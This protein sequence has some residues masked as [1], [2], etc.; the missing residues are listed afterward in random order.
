VDFA[1]KAMD[2]A[3]GDYS[4]LNRPAFFRSGLQSMLYMYKVFPTTSIQMFMNLSTNGKMGMLAG[5]WMLGGIAAFPFAEDLE[6]LFDTLLQKSGIGE[7]SVRAWA[8]KR[9]DEISPGLAPAVLKG[10]MGSVFMGDIA[11]RVSLSVVPGS[12]ILL[13][14]TN[15][16]RALEE[17]AGP[18]PSALLGTMQFASDLIR[19]P[20]STTQTLE[21]TLRG[22][23]V[24]GLR[25]AADTYAYAQT[26]AIIDRRGY[27]VAPNVATSE[28]VARL[29]GFYPRRAAEQYGNIRV[30]KRVADYRREAT[31]AYRQEWVAARV[32]NDRDRMQEI[33]QA[34]RDW[35]NYHRGSPLFIDNFRRNA[36]RAYR[37]ALRPAGERT[38][39]TLPRAGRDQLERVADALTF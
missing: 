36:Q 3:L 30:M 31:T 1:G 22:A 25:M 32:R 37:D 38:L 16:T 9:L 28:M 13:A 34:V 26:G 8:A 24:T 18:M 19:T 7:G 17:I 15:T 4:V 35:N 39:R 27:I 29:A 33:E 23:P 21:A 6:D 20:F 12:D 2:T 11:S 5:L 10:V 14:G